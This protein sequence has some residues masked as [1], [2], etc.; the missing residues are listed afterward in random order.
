[1]V[2]SKP[3]AIWMN[4]KQI[5]LLYGLMKLFEPSI[6]IKETEEKILF[7]EILKK[8]ENHTSEEDQK[9]AQNMSDFV[10]EQAK[11]LQSKVSGVK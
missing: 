3:T 5:S 8:I 7:Y 1:M 2:L 9:L 11:E 6:V 4:K 10:Q